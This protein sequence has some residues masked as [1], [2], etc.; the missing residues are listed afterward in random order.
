M[1]GKRGALGCGVAGVNADPAML[2]EAK[3]KEGA[4]FLSVKIL[5]PTT[6]L[7]RHRMENVKVVLKLPCV[8]CCPGK[9]ESHSVGEK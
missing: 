7:S 1:G 3:T 8:L 9:A 2:S 6:V 4:S 5:A